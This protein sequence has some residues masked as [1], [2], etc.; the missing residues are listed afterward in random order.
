MK[1]TEVGVFL[2]F[3][4]LSAKELERRQPGTKN[5]EAQQQRLEV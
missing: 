1:G 4:S 3:L 2:L 5:G